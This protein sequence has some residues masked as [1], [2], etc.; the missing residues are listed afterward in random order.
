MKILITSD[1]YAPAINGVV[2]SVLN[3]EK[4][5]TAMGHEV[6]VL[7]LSQSPHSLKKGNVT[8]IGAV[9]AGMI[10]PGARLR[11]APAMVLLRELVAWKPDIIHSQCEFSTFFMARKIAGAAG[12]PLVHTYHTVYEDYTHYFSPSRRW[13]RAAVAALTRWVVAQTEAVIAPTAKVRRLLESY[14][15]ERPIFVIPTGIDLAR[16]D[17]PVDAERLRELRRG[18]DIPQEA[19]VLVYVGRLAEE[20]NLPQL[21]RH[22]AAMERDDIRLLLV[23]DGPYRGALEAQVRSMGMEGIVRFAGMVAPAQVADYYRVGD[24][25]VSAS[26]SET[27]GLTYL[28][29]LACGLPALCLR[30]ECLTGVVIDGVNGCQFRDGVEFCR[31]LE[32]FAGDEHLRRQLSRGALETAR[33]EFSARTFAR[34]AVKLYEQ[35]LLESQGSGAA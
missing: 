32:R 31:F 24:L 34:R 17:A 6:R 26:A 2:T 13:G 8:Y 18:L 14:Q 19:L 33:R 15:V 25:F 7:T 23:G 30:D 11:T 3:L 22:V 20:K 28:E 27:Q 9:S 4:E 12:V 10:Y 21:L 16:F 5:L 35:V 1:W 29:A